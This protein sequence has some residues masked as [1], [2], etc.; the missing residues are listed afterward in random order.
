M[1]TS[2]S[3]KI[4]HRTAKVAIIGLGYVG[5]PLAL[6]FAKAG[7]TTV[8]IE[9]NETRVDDLNAGR[10]YIEDV[11]DEE[12]LPHI[13]AGRLSA[14]TDYDVVRGC[15]AAFI[16]VPTPYTIQRTPDLSYIISATEGIAPRLQP[17]P[18][19]GRM[20]IARLELRD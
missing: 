18:H 4:T 19:G 12:L 10:S 15:D 17:E 3:D 16:C 8:G 20:K 7:F 13:Q 6:A 5:L 11:T 1:N 2:I 14:T 9:V